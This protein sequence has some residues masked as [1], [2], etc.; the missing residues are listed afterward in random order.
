MGIFLAIKLDD[1]WI[2]GHTFSILFVNPME[3]DRL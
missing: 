3:V 2:E 1:V